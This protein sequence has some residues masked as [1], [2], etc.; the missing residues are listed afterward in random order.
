[1]VTTEA[2]DGIMDD[3]NPMVAESTKQKQS[4]IKSAPHQLAKKED[5]GLSTPSQVASSAKVPLSQ[6][7]RGTC[8]PSKA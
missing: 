1:M 2:E 7:E 8:A 4:Q 5:T 3:N 6:Y